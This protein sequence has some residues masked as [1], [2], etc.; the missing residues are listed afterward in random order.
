MRIND[1]CS[2]SSSSGQDTFQQMR[3]RRNASSGSRL[4]PNSS[5]ASPH[6]NLERLD[7]AI[8]RSSSYTSQIDSGEEYSNDV[9]PMAS[10]NDMNDRDEKNSN[11]QD[12]DSLDDDV[13]PSP[14]SSTSVQP[15]S[16]RGQR[17][18]KNTDSRQDGH[19]GSYQAS[20]GFESREKGAL[21]QRSTEGSK[22]KAK[23]N[24]Q[25]SQKMS[26]Q[27]RR[28]RGEKVRMQERKDR[29]GKLRSQ[30]SSEIPPMR[31][32]SSSVSSFVATQEQRATSAEAVNKSDGVAPS[33]EKKK[34]F[35][36]LFKSTYSSDERYG[37]FIYFHT[38]SV[39][40]FYSHE[41]IFVLVVS[42]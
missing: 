28:E 25:P 40:I 33:V 29:E 8:S 36:K 2:L 23:I 32:S 37:S 4:K 14:P 13:V 5:L 18:D 42:N 35:L 21:P 20:Q 26:A 15:S 11:E 7:K 19:H 27:Q 31:Q 41:L 6:I 22:S 3:L 16:D 38:S 17:A 10:D 1:P 9:S 12:D 24:E 30:S 39:L 34:L